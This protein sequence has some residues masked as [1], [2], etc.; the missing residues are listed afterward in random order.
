MK[1]EKLALEYYKN[2]YNCSQCILK[3]AADRFDIVLP[4]KCLNMCRGINNGFGV[5]SVCSVLVAAIITLGLFF[6]EQS[7]KRVRINFL[8]DFNSKYGSL[9]CAQLKSKNNCEKIISDVAQILE[10]IILSKSNV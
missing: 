8:N 6:N 2:G 5:G 3:A 7:L 1:M 4:K 10:K 9:N